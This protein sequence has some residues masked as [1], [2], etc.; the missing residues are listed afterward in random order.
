METKHASHTA[1]INLAVRI[2]LVLAIGGGAAQAE[3]A[4]K[5]CERPIFKQWKL[6]Q[7]DRMTTPNAETL[8]AEKKGQVFNYNCFTLD[9]IDHFFE[10]HENRIENAHFHPILAGNNA[11]KRE[12]EQEEEDDCE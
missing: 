11:T 3:S 5:V 10:D 1:M 9:E 8:R 6:Q 7:L 4:R 2:G 12:L